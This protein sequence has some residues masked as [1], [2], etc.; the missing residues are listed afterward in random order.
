MQSLAQRGLAGVFAQP[1]L[2]LNVK[3]SR[4]MKVSFGTCLTVACVLLAVAALA[5][6]P[7]SGY[8]LIKTV[9]I[10]AAPGSGEYFDY[11]TVDPAA[12]RVYVAHGSEVKVLDADDFSVVGSITGLKRCHGVALIPGLGKGFIT[13][14]EAARSGGIR[15]KDLE[16]YRTRSRLNRT[17]IRLPMIRL[18]SS[19]SRS[20]ATAKTRPSSIR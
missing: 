2:P 1:S 3:E 14:G 15:Y 16:S 10:G 12:R 9:P 13:D 8:H 17:Q 18:P 5:S 7:G 4:S 19:Y 20:T 11:V 6:P